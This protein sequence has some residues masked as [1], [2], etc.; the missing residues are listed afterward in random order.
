MA[1]VLLKVSATAEP[2][3]ELQIADGNHVAGNRESE[4]LLITGAKGD[5]GSKVLTC[6]WREVIR[7]KFLSVSSMS[8]AVS[9]AANSNVSAQRSQGRL[10]GQVPA[11]AML[12]ATY[13]GE[14]Y[15]VNPNV[16]QS[17]KP[18]LVADFCGPGIKQIPQ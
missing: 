15:S 7:P 5:T 18:F 3:F 2:H 8:E 1:K 12:S 11:D 10:I 4:T 16:R 17:E 14:A 6:F 9:L 13:S